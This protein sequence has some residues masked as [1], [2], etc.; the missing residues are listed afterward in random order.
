MKTLSRKDFISQLDSI[1]DFNQLELHIDIAI[2]AIETQCNQG[3][4]IKPTNDK[5]VN[6][7]TPKGEKYLIICQ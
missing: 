7:Y 2:Q 6:V 1:Y 4:V 3:F 5:N